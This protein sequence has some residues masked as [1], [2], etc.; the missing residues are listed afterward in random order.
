MKNPPSHRSAITPAQR[1]QIVQRVIID[2][3]T[4]AEVASS[5]NVSKRLVDVWVSD[6]RRNGMASL[7]RVPGRT[8][9]ATILQ[10]IVARPMRAILRKMS[11]GLRRPVAVEPVVQ[12]LPLRRSNEDASR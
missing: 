9:A 6:F 12:P 10:L 5:F 4:S 7:R 3:W 11:S 8:A 1:G 2:G